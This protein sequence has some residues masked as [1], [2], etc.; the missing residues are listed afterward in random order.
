MTVLAV[1]IILL[2]LYPEMFTTAVGFAVAVVR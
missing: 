1:G 2:G